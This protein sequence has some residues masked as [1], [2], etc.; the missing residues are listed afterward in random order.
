[1]GRESLKVRCLRCSHLATDVLY[2]PGLGITTYECPVC[3][4]EVDLKKVVNDG[5]PEEVHE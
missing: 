1:V 3:K 4:L 5:L 2:S